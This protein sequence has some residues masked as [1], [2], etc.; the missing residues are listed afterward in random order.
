MA[1]G[2]AGTDLIRMSR[3]GVSGLTPGEGLALLDH[4]VSSGHPVL[5]PV[6]LDTARLRSTGTAVPPLLRGLIRVSAPRAGGTP[7]AVDGFLR[8][9]TGSSR[10]ERPTVLLNMVRHEVAAVLGHADA[11]AVDGDMAFQDLGFDSL[12]A[13][14]LRNRLGV[15]TGLRLPA[16]LVFDH[17][18]PAALA[19]RL[20]AD[21]PGAADHE[22]ADVLAVLERVEAGV[23]EAGV[24]EQRRIAVA[25][26]LQHLLGMVSGASASYT[27]SGVELDTA[28]DDELFAL[29]DGDLGIA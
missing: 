11:G 9:L 24:D 26:Q 18:T 7:P 14:E 10:D 2:L 8:R 23:R 6:K 5:V 20:D 4:G 16:T 3:G 12:T 27:E 28:S 19:K 29:V 21:L 13:V 17:P 15:V 22:I 25:A 1:A